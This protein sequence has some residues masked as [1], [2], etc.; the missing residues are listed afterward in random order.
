MS[1][2]TLL[3]LLRWLLVI[4]TGLGT[5]LCVIGVITAWEDLRVSRVY[6]GGK[7]IASEVRLRVETLMFVVFLSMFAMSVW[8]M[9]PIDVLMT[10][11]LM[12]PI[13]AARVIFNLS[14]FLLLMMKIVQHRGRHRLEDYYDATAA[15]VVNA[16]QPERRR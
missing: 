5:L 10:L 9:T 12:Q 4:Q 2:Y 11:P 6:N 3:W 8:F 7:R 15:A 1:M 13:V 14:I 16:N